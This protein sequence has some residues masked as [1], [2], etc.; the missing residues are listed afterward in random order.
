M[1]AWELL[2]LNILRQFDFEWQSTSRIIAVLQANKSDIY[3]ALKKGYLESGDHTK[4]NPF[5]YG[6]DKL[7][8]YYRVTLKGLI[9]LRRKFKDEFILDKMKELIKHYFKTGRLIE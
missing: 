2:L 6:S 1:Y 5:A 9:Y 4:A 7:A 8:T 3:K